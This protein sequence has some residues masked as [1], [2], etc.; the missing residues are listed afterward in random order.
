M[1]SL[2]PGVAAMTFQ[3]EILLPLTA[4]DPEY[5]IRGC[6]AALTTEYKVRTPLVSHDGRR[7]QQLVSSRRDYRHRPCGAQGPRQCEAKPP[8]RHAAEA[9]SLTGE[10]LQ[11][12]RGRIVRPTKRA[13]GWSR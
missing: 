7:R 10:H 12:R 8:G 3:T 9:S 11:R 5:G 1:Y 4:D 13:V 2:L 6:S